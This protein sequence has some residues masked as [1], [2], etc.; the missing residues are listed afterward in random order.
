M[1]RLASRDA[2]WEAVTK[3][4]TTIRLSA[5]PDL[6]HHP[7]QRRMVD[8]GNGVNLSAQALGST[9]FHAEREVEPGPKGFQCAIPTRRRLGCVY[10]VCGAVLPECPPRNLPRHR[11]YHSRYEH[12]FACETSLVRSFNPTSTNNPTMEPPW[13]QYNPVN[14]KPS[15]ESQ[16][17]LTNIAIHF[18]PPPPPPPPAGARQ[19]SG[20]QSRAI[21]RSG[22][23]NERRSRRAPG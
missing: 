12:R 4:P 22:N 20:R 7:H 2:P 13:S 8:V 15:Q 3:R 21:A 14:G 5:C 17:A 11:T 23:S 10:K 18:P 9:H 19:A 16:A 1:Q 6:R